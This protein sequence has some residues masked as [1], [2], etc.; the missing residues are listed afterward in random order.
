MK[1]L[2]QFIEYLDLKKPVVLKV[3]T[4]SHKAMDGCYV[5]RYSDKTGK[6]TEHRITIYTKDTYRDFDTLVAHELIH[7]WQEEN[8]KTEIHG[9]YFKALAKD[10]GEYFGLQ[11]VYIKGVDKN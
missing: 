1:T 7:A 3:N 10:M 6:L 9:K 2:Q 11:E 5:P 8:K 4:R